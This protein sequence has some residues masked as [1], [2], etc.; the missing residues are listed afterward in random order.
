MKSRRIIL[1]VILTLFLTAC[2]QAPEHCGVEAKTVVFESLQEMENESDVIVRGIRKQDENPVLKKEKGN[3]VS[4]YTFSEFQVT[5]VY[6]D[7]GNALEKDNQITI[8][9]NEAYDEKENVIYHIAGYN[10]MEDGKE[11]LLFLRRNE[12]NGSEYYVSVGINYGTVSLQEDSRMT[13][14]YTREGNSAGDFSY[15]EPI[16]EAAR[17][18]YAE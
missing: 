15:Y 9:E 1:T 14:R 7:T 3:L 17:A 12:L 4:A 8:L 16:W 2:G 5:E 6:K 13:V 11:Y 18:K 10:M